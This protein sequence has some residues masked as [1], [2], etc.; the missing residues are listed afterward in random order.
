MVALP[1]K[2]SNKNGKDFITDLRASVDAYFVEKGI[3]TYADSRMVV[4]TIAL[5][6]LY[7]GAYALILGQVTPAWGMLGLAIVMGIGKAGIGFSIAH[8][9]IHGSYSKNPTVNRILGFS[10]NLIG[11]SAYVWKITHNMVHHTY[12]NIHEVDEDLE[13]TALMR[14]SPEAPYKKIHKY[15]YLYFPIVYSLATFFWVFAKDYK[16]LSQKDIGPYKN[17]KHSAKEI[18]ITFFGKILY[19]AYTIVIPL[20]VL[21]TITWWQFVIGFLVMHFTAGIILGV[22]FQLAHVVEQ[23]EHLQPDEQGKMENAWA[24]HQMRTTA[25]FAPKNRIVNWYVGGLNFQVEHHLFPNICSIHYPAISPIVAEVAARH[26]VP[27]YMNPT[28]R[29]AVMSHIRILKEFGKGPVVEMS[30]A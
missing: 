21:D 10:M 25:N 19:Y 9:A 23:T 12:T 1:I 27:Y 6:A 5:L 29:S 2:F 3:S 11:G 18:A 30:V 28:F 4:K 20:M 15:Q 8:D 7:F 14:L 13:V 17:Q 16:K 22:V 24:I 26:N